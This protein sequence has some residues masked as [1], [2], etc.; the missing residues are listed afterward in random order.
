MIRYITLALIASTSI[1]YAGDT[2]IDVDSDSD[3]RSTSSSGVYIA[4]S[5]DNT[6]GLGGSGS[7]STAPCVVNNGA[8]VVAPGAGVSFSWSRIARDC[9][10]RVEAQALEHL[11]G[12]EAAITH[13]CIHD[14][15]MRQ[16]LQAMG[17]C[18]PSRPQVVRDDYTTA[19]KYSRPIVSSS[20]IPSADV[21]LARSLGVEPGVYTRSELVRMKLSQ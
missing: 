12:R 15:S 8:G 18:R 2:T 14:R 19:G 21:Q 4:G 13:L 16:T 1:A 7:N 20:N 11:L 3:S 6:P 10:T 9:E 5:G 17:Y